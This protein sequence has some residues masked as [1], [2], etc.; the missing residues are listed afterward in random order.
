VIAI[1][2]LSMD[3]LETGARLGADGAVHALG[4][5]IRPVSAS[6]T[7]GPATLPAA[8]NA[9]VPVVVQPSEDVAKLVADARRPLPVITLDKLDVN[10]RRATVRNEAEPS[11]EPLEVRD[12]RL[13]N[14]SRIEMGGPQADAR[15]PVRLELTGKIAPV[16]GQIA[17][18][19]TMT[20]LAAEPAGTITLNVSGIRGSGIT[21]L[22][23]KLAEKIDGTGLTDGQF[24]TQL[25]LR[26]KLDKRGPRDIDLSRPFTLDVAVNDIA[27]TQGDTKYVGLESIR[28]DQVRVVPASG[29]VLAKTLEIVKPQAYAVREA[30][31]IHALG[32]IIKTPPPATSPTTEPT[33]APQPPAPEAPVAQAQPS[34]TDGEKRIDLLTISG[35]D[36]RVEDRSVEPQV[37]VPLNNLD[38]EARGLTTLALVEPRPIRFTA[39]VNSGKVPLKVHQKGAGIIG[40]VGDLATMIGGKKE[41]QPP[42]TTRPMEDRELFSQVA[43]AGQLSI[44][45]KPRG[46]VKTSISGV[47]LSAFEGVAKTV[48]VELTEGVF[49]GNVDVRFR[50]DGAIATKSKF[51]M[52]DLTLNE[53]PNGFISRHIALPG[54]LDAVI[55]TVRDADGSITL[56]PNVDLKEGQLSG[57]QMAGE[58]GKAIS[59]IIASAF[60]SAPQK[61]VGGVSDAIGITSLLGGDKKPDEPQPVV[62]QFVPGGVDLDPAARK[63]LDDLLE[64]AR[65]DENMQ[66]TIR[67]ELGGGDVAVAQQRGNP[68]RD[69]SL[70]MATELRSRKLVLAQERAQLAGQ[71]RAQLAS[72]GVDQSAAVLTRLRSLDQ[73]IGGI[74]L[75]LDQLYDLLK[76]GAER[77]AA[78]RT[79]AAGIEIG[80]VRAEAVRKLLSP[81]DL[82]QASERVKTAGVQFDP[83]DGNL[84]GRIVV[85]PVTKKKS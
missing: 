41:E 50:D 21:E 79:R 69:D 28:A 43:A 71:A 56:A 14:L 3:G 27:F 40:A 37:I 83:A 52:T 82:K 15:P 67:H 46:Y 49:D 20:P 54:P 48:G 74:E 16:V 57:A 38:V 85:T 78:R 19:A 58:A 23:P 42:P 55:K 35:L 64:Q 68:S 45:P 32:L 4:V 22:L 77:Q 60:A 84:G 51:V 30:D 26:A 70:A 47:E 44:Y 25:Q 13:H 12:L 2:E 24:H 61:L 80:R 7:G 63:Q 31:G 29:S 59:S 34:S 76:P 75:S 73:Q 81:P 18:N 53:G 65:K 66:L 62:I 1:D 17:L 11:A 36:V 39:L 33:I 9:P 8:T 10:V 6:Q 5:T 72:I